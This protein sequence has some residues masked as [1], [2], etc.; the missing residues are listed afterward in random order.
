MTESC[1]KCISIVDLEPSMRNVNTEFK[2]ISVS[3]PKE[4]HSRGNNRVQRVADATVGDDSGVVILT[5]WNEQIDR[6]R[7]GETYRLENGYTSLFR[8]SLRLKIGRHGELIDAPDSIDDINRQMNLSL[9]E[10][11]PRHYYLGY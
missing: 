10:Q 2:V 6:V 7:I 11:E 4:I 1:D 3:Y 9:Q 8:G 5:L